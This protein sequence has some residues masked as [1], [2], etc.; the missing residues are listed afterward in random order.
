M[1]VLLVFFISL[2]A[3]GADLVSTQLREENKVLEK[4]IEMNNQIIKARESS[5]YT[6]ITDK[7]DTLIGKT[8]LS[9][10]LERINWGEQQDGYAPTVS[11]S[12]VFENNFGIE[13]SYGQFRNYNFPGD[14]DAA[15][16]NIYH[17][18]IKYNYKTSWEGVSIQPIIGYVYYSV[19][20][21]DG[22]I[23]DDSY[24]EDLENSELDAI[25]DRSGLFSGI[26]IV[27]SLGQNWVGTLRG[28]IG[29]SV[30][31][32]LGHTL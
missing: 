2:S 12:H 20:S 19:N 4:Q 15:F 18:Q 5:N 22:G 6:F 7:K 17:S 30:T 11:V 1:K 8:T 27:K 24:L 23:A 31:I 13:G 14:S 28:D 3:Y 32:Q 10:G 26:A 9:L 25:R 21:P 16:T 29:K